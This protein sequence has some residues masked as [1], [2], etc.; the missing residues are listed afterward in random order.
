MVAATSLTHHALGQPTRSASDQWLATISL[1]TNVGDVEK[2]KG[3][4]G[5]SIGYVGRRLG[6]ELDLERYWHFFKD[7]DI[8]N[9]G[10]VMAEDVDTR[11]T[12]LMGNLVVPIDVGDAT[13]WRPYGIAGLG[14]I[15]ATFKRSAVNQSDVHQTDP[16][17]NVGAG[18][19]RSLGSRVG[20]RGD[21]QYFRAFAETNKALPPGQRGDVSGFYRDYG[22]LRGTVAVT[23]RFP[24]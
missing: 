2:R 3:G 13:R 20:L 21:L 10:D 9:T 19:I 11:A 6:F 12:S 23:V 1:G 5:G 15:R 22:F 7:S 18:V 14:V 8:G 24:R 17:F 16:A 4:I